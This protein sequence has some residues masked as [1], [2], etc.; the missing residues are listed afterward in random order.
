MANSPASQTPLGSLL[1][2]LGSSAPEIQLMGSF[3]RQQ[4]ASD[5]QQARLPLSRVFSGTEWPAVVIPAILLLIHVASF[6]VTRL[7]WKGPFLRKMAPL[8][9]LP[10]ELRQAQLPLWK[11][12]AFLALT[13][14]LAA[15]QF[16]ALGWKQAASTTAGSRPEW[17]D[18]AR[19]GILVRALN[20]TPEL[21]DHT[22][23]T[24]TCSVPTWL[25]N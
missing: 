1:L 13:V 11:H 24:H 9:S 2:S 10:V 20:D 23:H 12:V 21:F 5:L 14:A 4:E 7:P 16:L 8:D 6:K 15:A 18:W 17:T 19:A 3:N 22:A 25:P